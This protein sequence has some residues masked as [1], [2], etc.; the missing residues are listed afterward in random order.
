[1][2][3]ESKRVEVSCRIE[4]PA[5]PIFE[6]LANPRRHMDFDGSDMLRGP[7]T[8]DPSPAWVTPSP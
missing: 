7:S 3:E 5:A 6:I 1:M 8:T 2:S 4:A